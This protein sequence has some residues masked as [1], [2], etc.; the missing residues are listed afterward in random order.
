MRWL[1]GITDSM[2]MRLSK[3]LEIVKD[4]GSRCVAVYEVV[5]SQIQLSD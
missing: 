2:N 4:R 1:N 3:L 5:K